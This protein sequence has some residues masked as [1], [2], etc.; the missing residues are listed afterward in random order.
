MLLKVNVRIFFQLKE[1]REY[2][3]FFLL[4]VQKDEEAKYWLKILEV[5]VNSHLRKVVQMTDSG[6]SINI[7]WGSIMFKNSPSKKLEC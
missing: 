3:I 5:H 2:N 4:A 6:V 1:K 7:K